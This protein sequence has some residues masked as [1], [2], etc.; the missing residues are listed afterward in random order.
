MTVVPMIL[1]FAA[2]QSHFVRGLTG[3]VKG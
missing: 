1:F 2:L 3:A